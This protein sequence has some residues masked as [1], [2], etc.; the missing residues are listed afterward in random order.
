MI[1]EVIHQF[2][3]YG[4][5]EGVKAFGSGHINST[6]QSVW[7]QA[8][9]KLRY[10]HQKINHQVFLRPDEVMENIERVTSHL[11]ACASRA[12][13][14]D[15]SRRTLT[16]VPSRDGKLW[17]R[18][19]EGGWWRTYLFIEGSHTLELTSSPD[20]ARFLGESIARFQSQ[21]A[22]L[23]GPRLHETI[24]GFHDME[25]RYARFHEALSKDSHNRAK[26]VKPEI[27]FM[28]KN[29]ERGAVLIRA[30]RNGAIP[31]RICHNDAKINN[32]LIDD[33]GSQA[34]CVID[35]DTVMPGTSLFDL[36]DL[37]RSVTNRAAE[38]EKDLSKVEFDLGYFE[39]LLAG[40]L[41]GA[42]EFLVPPELALL[43][44]SGRNLTQIMGLR[45]LTDYLEGD[46][47]YHIDRQDHNIDRCRTQIALINS[48]D[49]K[50]DA[51]HAIA[52]ELLNSSSFLAEN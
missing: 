32:I 22:S 23:G 25:K 27:A 37:I 20:D 26:D 41:T 4:E 50:W 31:E 43:C 51:A 45:F 8:G 2:A 40:Y 19:R 12:G 33:A 34:L 46:R 11:R 36:G 30:L 7:N 49:S 35:L 44:E 5:F 48:M 42:R 9:T 1:N 13:L 14:T 3:I 52:Q 47:Y 10:T 39:A 17:V 16:V 6:F 24:P 18:D 29:E 15:T 21:L 28:Q 38:D